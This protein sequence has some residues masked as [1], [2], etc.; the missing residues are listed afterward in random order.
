MSSLPESWWEGMEVSR[1]VVV[2]VE[3]GLAAPVQ[4]LVVH[5]E[6]ILNV[7]ELAVALLVNVHLRHPVVR[8]VS[9]QVATGVDKKN[10]RKTIR[11]SFTLCIG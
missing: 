5:C 2:V 3:A 8:L 11:V 4:Q 10:F 6:V 9:G 7:V 1:L